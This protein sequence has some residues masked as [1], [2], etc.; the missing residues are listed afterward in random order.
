MHEENEDKKKTTGEIRKQQQ[1][2]RQ[3]AKYEGK[4]AEHNEKKKSKRL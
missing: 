4:E 2:G 1:M 3:K